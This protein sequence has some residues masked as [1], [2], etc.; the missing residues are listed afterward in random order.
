M[1]PSD[2]S[3]DG[4]SDIIR[5]I[6][7]LQQLNSSDYFLHGKSD[8]KRLVGNRLIADE[9]NHGTEQHPSVKS[10][11][12]PKPP[13]TRFST[14]QPL[15]T[16]HDTGDTSTPS[17]SSEQS[18]NFYTDEIEARKDLLLD[19]L[20]LRVYNIFDAGDTYDQ[21]QRGSSDPK[22]SSSTKPS[23]ENTSS[24]GT[25][26]HSRSIN[27]DEDNNDENS[28]D[29][30]NKRPRIPK[31]RDEDPET[32]ITKP[33]AC[34]FFKH[35]PGRYCNARKCAGPTGWETIARLK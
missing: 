29:H 33:F 9:N 34:P 35:N 2:K 18:L 7:E 32:V 21:N 13:R 14:P 4:N 11:A 28:N 17:D 15:L 25:A 16:D 10:G 20:M 24:R 3:L 8:I 5:E 12:Y 30:V 23:T 6:R 26:K 27:D 1:K 31:D 22:K 19:R